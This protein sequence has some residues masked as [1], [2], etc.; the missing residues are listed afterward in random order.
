MDGQRGKELRRRHSG[1]P[2]FN[3][4]RGLFN[5]VQQGMRAGAAPAQDALRNDIAGDRRGVAA[6][7]ASS[8]KGGQ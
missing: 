3:E 7:R 1:S 6:H 5:R 2:R 8:R 4:I